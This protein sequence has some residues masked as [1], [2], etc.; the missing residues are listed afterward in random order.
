MKLRYRLLTI[1]FL[2]GL[3]AL[4]SMPAQAQVGDIG[5]ILQS[6]REDANTLARAYLEPFGSGF[7]ASL[8]TGWTNTASPHSKFGFDLTVSSGL[9][10]V[11]DAAK[12]FNVNDLGLKKL[13]LE[14]SDPVS[15]T[16]NGVDET[17]ASLA[18]YEEINNNREKILEFNMPEGSGF[19][20]VP[21]PMIKAGVGLIKDTELMVRYTPETEIGDFG[22]FNLFGVGAK[23]GINQWLPGGKMLPVNLSVMF[24][25][26]D[27]EVG[28]DLDLSAEDVIEEPSRTEN[29]YNASQWD[30]Q[31]VALNTDAW[32]INALVGK[33]LPIISVYAGVGYEASSFNVKT[34]G[35]YPTVIPNEDYESDPQNNEPLIVD[36]VDEP[37]DV[38]IDG[39]NGFR[40]LAGFR[41][42]AAI[43]HISGSY[44]LSNYSSYNLGVGISF[45]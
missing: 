33:S 11:P 38:S 22:S 39:D 36:A 2:S 5:D 20:Y 32:T 17:G 18:Y 29:P 6:G 43:F 19:G 15:P 27:M 28:S 35:S 26:T 41:F 16:I 25:Y 24:G 3:F 7:G 23:H 13:E 34:A 31:A 9:A 1:V 8:N 4:T 14:G 40:A 12:S 21:A 10:I 45:R 44:T 42:R 30:G 37:I